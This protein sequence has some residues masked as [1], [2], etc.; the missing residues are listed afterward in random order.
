MISQ[1]APLRTL[2][3][4]QLSAKL[5]GMAKLSLHDL[6]RRLPSPADLRSTFGSL[7]QDTDRS[8]AIVAASV[9]ENA[10]ERVIRARMLVSRRDLSD[11]LFGHRGPV[12]DFNGKIQIAE[13]FGFIAPPIAFDL[14]LIRKIRNAFAHAAS[15][16]GFSTPEVAAA[17]S[18]FAILNAADSVP[19][20][21]RMPRDKH[22]YL[23]V[24]QIILLF[25]DTDLRSRGYDVVMHE[26]NS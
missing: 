14:Q 18:N 10:L 13:A 16:I 23:M 17:M 15:N 3:S 7:S 2:S 9:A 8:V 24:V 25:L 22:G 26:D 1:I 5:M 12:S 6:S 4:R 20:G 11:G 21:L 19:Q